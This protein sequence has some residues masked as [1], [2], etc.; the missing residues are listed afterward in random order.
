MAWMPPVRRPAR[1]HLLGRSRA[2]GSG[3]SPPAGTRRGSGD[4][5]PP[6]HSSVGGAPTRSLSSSRHLPGGSGFISEVAER[7][8]RNLLPP[9]RPPCPD[10]PG[11]LPGGCQGRGALGGRL[12]PRAGGIPGGQRWVQG[13][14]AR[15]CA[16]P[17]FPT[18][19]PAPP[20][21]A[22][23]APMGGG[24]WHA[25]GCPPHPLPSPSRTPTFWPC[26]P[27]D[28]AP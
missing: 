14:M 19:K 24:E 13:T 15:G 4:P 17:N 6:P 7:G 23:S 3:S 8:L 2:V 21:G 28:A 10:P 18:S 12:S 25:G 16:A 20:E 27:G 26:F 5:V 9:S 1:D 22:G 11:H